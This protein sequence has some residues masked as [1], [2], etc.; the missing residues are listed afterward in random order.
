MRN[1]S[2]IF[3]KIKMIKNSSVAIDRHLN[4]AFSFQKARSQ[5]SAVG[6]VGAL[7]VWGCRFCVGRVGVS[8]RCRKHYFQVCFLALPLLQCGRTRVCF[9]ARPEPGKVRGGW[10][11][12][13][14]KT[15]GE[16]RAVP[17][18]KRRHPFSMAV[19]RQERCP[20]GPE[21]LSLAKTKFRK[22]IF[23]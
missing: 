12:S 16:K 22:K 7:L 15:L 17:V 20:C 13:A 1:V 4:T 19:T 14:V 11:C 8:N 3:R 6:F 23:I 18:E 2:L 5:V 21:A 9:G 10:F